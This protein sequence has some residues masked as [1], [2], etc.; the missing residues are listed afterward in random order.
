MS[1]RCICDDC[2]KRLGGRSPI[3]EMG[4]TCSC[5]AQPALHGK[6]YIARS[7]N[8]TDV[9]EHYEQRRADR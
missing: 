4:A 7:Q 3:F 1:M 6:I 5:A 9:C 2:G 8:P